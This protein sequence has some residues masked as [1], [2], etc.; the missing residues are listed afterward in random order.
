MKSVHED[1]DARTGKIA[2]IDIADIAALLARVS[3]EGDAYDVLRNV[4]TMLSGQAHEP[5][6]T[7]H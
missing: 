5:R 1:D 7:T 4:L 6:G 2:G 3:P